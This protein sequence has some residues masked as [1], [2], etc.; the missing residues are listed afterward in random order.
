VASDQWPVRLGSLISVR[1]FEYASSAEAQV[2]RS[3]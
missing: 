2:L 1:V 3:L